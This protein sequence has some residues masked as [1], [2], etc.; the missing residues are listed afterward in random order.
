VGERERV[1]R[2]HDAVREILLRERDPIGVS[3]APEAQNEYDSYAHKI[4]GRSPVGTPGIAS[5]CI[6]GRSRHAAWD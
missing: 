6:S 4:C 5:P 3:D 2:Y 1:G